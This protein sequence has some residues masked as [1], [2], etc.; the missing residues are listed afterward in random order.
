MT[1]QGGRGVT[2]TMESQ[3]EWAWVKR[4]MGTVPVGDGS[5]EEQAEQA[6]GLFKDYT[7]MVDGR[8]KRQTERELCRLMWAWLVLRRRHERREKKISEGSIMIKTAGATLLGTPKRVN[9]TATPRSPTNPIEELRQAT[10]AQTNSMEEE[11]ILRNEEKI[12]R[13]K[14]RKRELERGLYTSQIKH[15]SVKFQG[16]LTDIKRRKGLNGKVSVIIR[17]LK[18]K[19]KKKRYESVFEAALLEDW[20]GWGVEAD[21]DDWN[22][23]ENDEADTYPMRAETERFD[24]Y[25]NNQPEVKATKE[26]K[27]LTAQEKRAISLRYK[28][29]N[30]ILAADKVMQDAQEAIDQPSPWFGEYEAEITDGNDNNHYF[31]HRGRPP[32]GDY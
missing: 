26:K 31:W 9:K 12:E 27:Q 23:N 19:P 32:E 13:L 7:K 20:E 10:E 6:V 11:R 28:Y 3:E 30:A 21:W 15:H 1:P 18:R 17:Q 8:K 16:V 14:Q 4:V 22:W 24:W 25:D 5:E 29:R 2:E